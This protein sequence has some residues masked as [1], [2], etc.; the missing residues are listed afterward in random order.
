MEIDSMMLT[1]YILDMMDEYEG[2]QIAS[3]SFQIFLT[4]ELVQS[5]EMAGKIAKNLQDEF[6]SSEHLF[7]ALLEIP[8]QAREILAKFR[9][10]KEGVMQVLETVRNEKK[11]DLTGPKKNKA[12][13][14]FTKNLTALARADKL[15]PVIGR[16]E[17]TRRVMEILSRRTKNNP[18]LIGEAGVGKTAIAE[19]LAI[20]IAKGEA[21]ESLR[22]RE[23][24]SLD[25][26]ILLAG[27]NIGANLK[28]D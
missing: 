4:P 5:F 16:D 21:P 9:V 12:I 24:V 2:G 18:I 14:K 25:L 19:G 3:P 15:D 22:D 10:T 17:E 28:K 27:T 6:V 1:D 7:L 11:N 23:I 8:S 20:R 13:E 26:G